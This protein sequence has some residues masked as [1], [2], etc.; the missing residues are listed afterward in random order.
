ML[1]DAAKARHEECKILWAKACEQ[2]KIDPVNK[3]AIFS[4]GNKWAKKYNKMVGL[5]QNSFRE[6]E[7][8]C[9][10]LVNPYQIPL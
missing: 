3:F 8:I 9:N 1:S 2:D 7:F 5:M 4:K 10:N 6:T